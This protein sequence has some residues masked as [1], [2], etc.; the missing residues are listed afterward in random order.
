MFT[1]EQVTEKIADLKSE[2]DLYNRLVSLAKREILVGIPEETNERPG[3]GEMNNATLLFIHTN[4]SPVNN[5]P[6]R[7]V[8]EPAIEQPENAA[9]IRQGL[10]RVTRFLLEEKE[11]EAERT[12]QAVGE[13]AVGMIRDWF[14]DPRN[15][16]PPNTPATVKGKLRRL[17][18]KKRKEALAVYAA[19]ERVDTPLIDTGEMR[20][21]ITFVVRDAE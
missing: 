9:K 13:D 14:V 21:A 16:W 12:M 11:S 20:K 8:I 7:P 3:E 1:I 10:R 6:P 15:G 4:G 19:G 2:N 17:K 18:G 5:L